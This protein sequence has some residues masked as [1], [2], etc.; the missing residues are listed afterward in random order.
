MGIVSF[1]S[2]YDGLGKLQQP[3][4]TWL[5]DRKEDIRRQ[6]LLGQLQENLIDL[7]QEAQIHTAGAKTAVDDAEDAKFTLRSVEKEE[8]AALSGAEAARLAR[9]EEE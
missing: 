4:L 1:L 3:Y 5:Q 2:H 7:E 6:L 9:N 8:Q